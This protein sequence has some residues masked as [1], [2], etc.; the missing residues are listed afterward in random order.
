M[1]WVEENAASEYGDR[2]IALQI[3]PLVF[4]AVHT[5]TQASHQCSLLLARDDC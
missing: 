4:G 5:T 1:N 3:G 2:D